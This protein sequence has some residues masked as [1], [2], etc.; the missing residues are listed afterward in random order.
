M[1]RR[2]VRED[3]RGQ[4]VSAG[5]NRYRPWPAEVPFPAD[6]VASNRIA[7]SDKAQQRQG[8]E[9]IVTPTGFPGTATIRSTE[10]H[11]RVAARELWISDSYISALA[12]KGRSK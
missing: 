9:V 11:R 8:L 7:T 10:H 2:T 1:P 4:Y 12:E 5:G 3:K 6:L